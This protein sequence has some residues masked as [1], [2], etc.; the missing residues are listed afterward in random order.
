M[1]QKIIKKLRIINFHNKYKKYKNIQ[2][3]GVGF[4]ICDVELSFNSKV[5][6]SKNVF[7]RPGCA[8]RVRDNANLTIGNNVSFNNNCILTCRENI[9][10]GN[11]VFIGPNVLIFDHD[12]DYKSND[13]PN[14]FKSAPI[15]IED[16]VWIGGNC[17]ILKGSVIHSGAVIGAG[18]IVKGDVEENTLL[19]N[20]VN[21]KK[22]PYVRQNEV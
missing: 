11:N 8:V 19:V 1:F 14:T 15:I 2:W 10:I 12:H 16:N 22:Y 18:T 4:L 17:I 9:S 5:N 13:M 20:K 6:V 7:F 3:N 21:N